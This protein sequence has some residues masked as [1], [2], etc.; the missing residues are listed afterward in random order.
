[1]PSMCSI[2]PVDVFRIS[3]IVSAAC[4][5]SRYRSLF[6]REENQKKIWRMRFKWEKSGIWVNRWR[7]CDWLTQPSSAGPPSSLQCSAEAYDG[8]GRFH[9]Y[10]RS[11]TIRRHLSRADCLSLLHSW[12]LSVSVVY[13]L[14][15]RWCRWNN[16]NKEISLVSMCLQWS[17]STSCLICQCLLWTVN[18]IFSQ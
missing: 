3:P 11:R 16:Q 2:T 8:F 7:K 6:L 9:W 4:R 12:F 5:R 14:R 13:F 18:V 1:M 15:N 17:R 10:Y